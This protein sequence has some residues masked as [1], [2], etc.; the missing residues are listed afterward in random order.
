MLNYSVHDDTAT[1][2][3]PDGMNT[4]A[5][6]AGPADVTVT[7][8]KPSLTETI[9]D[10]TNGQ[11]LYSGQKVTYTLTLCNN[12]D[13]TAYDIDHAITL[14]SGL[15]G[16]TITGGGN[17]I[18]VA[19]G[20]T[21]VA[22]SQLAALAR[23]ASVTYTITG[24]VANDLPADTQLTV[25]D[26]YTWHS[27]PESYVFMPPSGTA[28]GSGMH[29]QNRRMCLKPSTARSAMRQRLAVS[30]PCSTLW[31]RAMTRPAASPTVRRS[32]WPIPCPATRSPCRARS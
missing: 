19:A 12:G 23:G 6:Q 27:A 28:S 25:T 7:E 2:D 18:T 15:T 30:R 5:E 13:V 16:V 24:T 3:G 4:V 10:D 31:V 17:T 1:V 32:L 29:R 21:S 20:Q 22:L 26:A 14:P 9:T 11:P 8:R